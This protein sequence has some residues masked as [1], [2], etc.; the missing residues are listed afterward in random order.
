[1]KNILVEAA[2]ALA[3]EGR[4]DLARRLLASSTIEAQNKLTPAERRKVR[5]AVWKWWSTSDREGKGNDRELF[6]YSH[7]LAR[8]INR[9]RHENVKLNDLSD[10]DLMKLARRVVPS[11]STDPKLEAIMCKHGFAGC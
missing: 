5:S 9:R 7:N 3:K 11:F 4:E 2:A 6:L 8:T 10:D 1:M